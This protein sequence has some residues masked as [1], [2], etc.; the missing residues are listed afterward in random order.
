MITSYLFRSLLTTHFTVHNMAFI[1]QTRMLHLSPK[2]LAHALCATWNRLW[3]HSFWGKTLFHPWILSSDSTFSKKLSLS[4]I[5]GLP[6]SPLSSLCWHSTQERTVLTELAT[7]YYNH[8]AADLK[9]EMKS[10]SCLW[11]YVLHS[12]LHMPDT[13][14]HI[15]P[16]NTSVNLKTCFNKML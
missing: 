13:K 11:T 2:A 1:S 10:W 8:L 6:R 3:P 5:S 15:C 14:R 12:A 7:R 9:G 16:I 4:F